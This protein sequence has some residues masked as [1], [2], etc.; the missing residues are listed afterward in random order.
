ML[1]SLIFN[2]F[3]ENKNTAAAIKM[4]AYMKNN[5]LFLGIS[6]PKRKLLQKEFL[7]DK[8][9]TKKIDWEFVLTCFA[10]PEREF[11]Y[12]ALDYLIS[13]KKF[14]EIKDIEI[15]EH[16]IQTKSWWDTVDGFDQI[17]GTLVQ[18]YPKIVDS[19]IRNWMRSNNIWLVRVSINF[20]LEYKQNTMPEVLAE[21]ILAN[22]GS[23]EFFINKAIG[24]SLRQYAKYNKNWVINFLNVHQQFL[25]PLSLREARKHF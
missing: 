20:Q 14:V 13:L 17:V 10:Q 4:A 12:M 23:K 9:K 1:Y 5:F 3:I 2:L 16:L 18:K 7:R 15:I 11:Q 21:A 6:S 24:W 25:S 19:H 22:I 8:I